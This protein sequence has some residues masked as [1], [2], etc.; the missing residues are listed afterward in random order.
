MKKYWQILKNYKTSLILSPILV[1][2]AVL[3]ETIQPMFMAKIVDD[4][5]MQRDLSV[6][7]ETGIYMVLISIAGLT[8]SVINV[9]VSSK[10]SIG[11]GT[12]LRTALFDKIQQLSFFDIDHFSSASLITRLTNDIS[13][14]QQIILMSMRMMLRSPLMLVM[15]LFFVITINTDLALILLIAIPVLGVSVFFILRKGFPFFLKVQQKVDQLN[16]VVRENLINIRVVKSFVREDFEADKFEKSSGELRDMVIHAS[17]IVASIFPVMQLVLNVSI[18]AILWIGGFKVMEGELKVG[19]LISF[20]NYLSQVLMALMMLS[21]IFMNLAR[22]SASSERILEVLNANPSLVNTPEGLQDKYRVTRGEV[23]FK[24]VSFRYPSGETDVLRNIN[25]EVKPGETIAIVGATGSAKSSLVQLIP[26]LYD[27]TSGEILID[28]ISVKSYH[29]DELHV[30][31]GMVLQK[32]ELFTGT[33]MENLRWGKEDATLAEVEEA[34]IAAQAHE[35]IMS[36]PEGYNTMLG[37]GGVNVSGGQKQRICIA[38][39]LLRKPQILILDDSTS[40]VDTETEMKIRNN[41]H[42]LLNNTTVFIITQRINTM[43]SA[44]KV[45]VLEDGEIN[46]IGTPA[47]LLENSVVYQEIYNSQQIVF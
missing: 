4:G 42:K 32:N 30:R 11:F 45:I 40:A 2:V 31:I 5:V 34:C 6:V 26:R 24:N 16:E 7:T 22:A 33:I 15:A 47:E 43:Q 37:R 19:E 36:F 3:C 46:A 18:V 44:D 20:V 27:V 39:A 12:D 8:V 23:V 35:F 25:F 10:A 13:K 29:L 41:L 21:M 17:N 28:G 38:R 9:Y 1:L 14:I